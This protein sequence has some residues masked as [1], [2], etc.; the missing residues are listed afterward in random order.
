MP[1]YGVFALSKKRLLS[2]R[3]GRG[4]RI[5]IKRRAANGYDIR[6]CRHCRIC[7]ADKKS[8]SHEE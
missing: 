8:R 5:E 2:C 1:I 4:W 7:G 3:Q 6:V